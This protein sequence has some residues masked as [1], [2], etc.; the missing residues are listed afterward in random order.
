MNA[1]DATIFTAEP[2]P[3]HEESYNRWN[4]HVREQNCDMR[5]STDPVKLYG[6]PTVAKYLFD[7]ITFA[8]CNKAYV[9]CNQGCQGQYVRDTANCPR[10]GTTWSTLS[11]SQL[12]ICISMCKTGAVNDHTY[13]ASATY[14]PA[15]LERDADFAFCYKTVRSNWL[16]DEKS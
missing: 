15:D 8:T 5:H 14:G 11:S 9:T 3:T 10:K 1:L 2:H 13:I 6:H 12:T 4:L 16:S 7:E